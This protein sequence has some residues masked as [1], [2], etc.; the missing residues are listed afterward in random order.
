MDTSTIQLH[1]SWLDH[2]KDEFQQAYM[3]LIK[4]ILLELKKNKFTKKYIFCLDFSSKLFYIFYEKIKQI[5]TSFSR[6]TWKFRISGYPRFFQIS[7]FSRFSCSSELLGTPEFF[8][9]LAFPG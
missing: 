5:K 3:V 4:Q 7:H 1:P 6:T 9:R 2:L 8:E